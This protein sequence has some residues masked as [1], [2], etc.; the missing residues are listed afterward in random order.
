MLQCHSIK[1]VIPI[2]QLKVIFTELN[3]AY[4]HRH[5]I[6][7][8]G[9]WFDRYVDFGIVP[10]VFNDKQLLN[11]DIVSSFPPPLLL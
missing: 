11:L 9:N 8:Y 10:D 3:K 1:P 4:E 7:I 6:E 2:D 5:A